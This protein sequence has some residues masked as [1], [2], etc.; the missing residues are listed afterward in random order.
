MKTSQIDRSIDIN[1]M[2]EIEQISLVKKFGIEVYE[3]IKN[4][5]EKVECT[6]ARRSWYD[7]ALMNNPSPA[8]QL[9]AVKVRPKCIYLIRNPCEE[10]ISYLA[11]R[12]RGVSQSALPPYRTF[13][14]SESTQFNIIRNGD[15]PFSIAYIQNP[16][17]KVQFMAYESTATLTKSSPRFSSRKVSDSEIAQI[18]EKNRIA[19]KKMVF[20]KINNPCD[21]LKKVH[22]DLLMFNPNS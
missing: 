21:E 10:I 19:F 11:L 5:T 6:M 22:F 1:D 18:K 12:G 14:V 4:P 20:D 3:K 7:I 2:S 13:N 16:T 8:A 15:R 9:A 17:K